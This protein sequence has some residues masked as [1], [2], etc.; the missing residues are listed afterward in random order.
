MA[1]QYSEYHPPNWIRISVAHPQHRP[2]TLLR[3]RALP[4]ALQNPF[5]RR[6]RDPG[7][8]RQNP[9]S[10][11]RLSRST[12]NRTMRMTRVKS[13]QKSTQQ[14]TA[15][16]SSV[17]I[18]FWSSQKLKRITSRIW[19]CSSMCSSSSCQVCRILPTRPLASTP[20]YGMDPL[21]LS[22]IVT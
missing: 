14:I 10:L 16:G 18:P 5:T 7:Q 2:R 4:R 9:P 13:P 3:W 17:C 6:T 11:R 12:P 19:T 20:L 22:C 15:I 8:V 1:A 21:C